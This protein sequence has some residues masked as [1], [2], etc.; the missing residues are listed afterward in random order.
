[1]G[2]GV[3]LDQANA[4][5][6]AGRMPEAI[7]LLSRVVAKRPRE[8]RAL[9]MLGVA[10]AQSG[11]QGEAAQ[12][13]ERATREAPRDALI[14]TDLATL[15]VMTDRAA[16]AL[17]LLD[18]A[19]KLQPAL[20]QAS[21]Y[22]GVALK[23]LKRTDEALA[24]FEALAQQ[25]PANALY[26]HNR[27]SL[28]VQRGRYDEAEPIVERLLARDATAV[29]VLLVKSLILARRKQLNEAIA[30]CD[31][32]LAR[33]P[34]YEEARYNRGLFKL[35]KGDLPSGWRD[36]ESRWKRP[37]YPDP[38]PTPTIPV[39][40]G[41]AI[42]GRSILVYCEQGFGDSLHFCR[43]VGEL[44]AMGG[45]VTL[46]APM[47]LVRLLQTLSD[48]VRVVGAI[49]DKQRF[50]FQIALLSLPHRCNTDLANI[51]H[52]VPYL[53]VEPD[54]VTRWKDAIGAQGFKIGIAWQG[55]PQTDFDKTR[56]I[57]LREYL[58][59]SQIAGVRLISLQ[60]NFGAEQIKT[61]PAGMTVETL[62]DD[63]DAGPDAFLD[64][65]AVMQHLDL[66]VAP[67]TAIAHLAGA[68]ARPVFIPLDVDSDWR[69]LL[70]RT[71]SPWYP[72]AKLF[73]QHTRGDWVPVFEAI[74]ND[75]RSRLA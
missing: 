12:L 35:L 48:K 40:Q 17:P 2:F 36:H 56:S 50:D 42:N 23:N 62:G 34:G 61:L 37:G 16:E 72:T 5:I 74:A 10:K 11:A 47:P 71:D 64:T 3:E 67:N 7:A 69:W 29:P 53:A 65:A 9:H 55:N 33:A 24:T 45:D 75:V 27:A 26:Q 8:A 22:R 20:R 19:L 44:A 31:D 63:F 51:P 6:G 68:L 28:L 46:L 30:L 41:E 43:Y 21:F 15:K 32:V 57:A 73:R 13:L 18:K 1:M 58:P 60:K 52:R 39:W 38:S 54:R 66:V 25:E 59:L 49:N 70:E 14:L 4:L